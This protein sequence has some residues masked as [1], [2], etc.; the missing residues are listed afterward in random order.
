MGGVKRDVKRDVKRGLTRNPTRGVKARF[1]PGDPNA[2]QSPA[3]DSC[4][5]AM[6][7]VTFDGTSFGDGNTACIS[8]TGNAWSA[9]SSTTRPSRAARCAT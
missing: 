3:N 8:C 5:C 1:Q 7:L 4:R 2:H 9:S 6:K